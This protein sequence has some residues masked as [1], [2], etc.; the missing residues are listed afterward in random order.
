MD[1]N[2]QKDRFWRNED[3]GISAD[4][5]GFALGPYTVAR[6]RLDSDYFTDSEWANLR[7]LVIGKCLKH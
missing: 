7:T 1:G 3:P 5:K 2:L 6:I 4:V